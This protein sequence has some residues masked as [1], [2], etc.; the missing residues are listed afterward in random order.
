[1]S[2]FERAL[3]TA[4]FAGGTVEFY[5]TVTQVFSEDF[6][7]R[8][9]EWLARDPV[10]AVAFCDR[11]RQHTGLSALTNQTIMGGL[12]NGRKKGIRPSELSAK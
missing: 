5:T 1:M 7:G 10:Q 3:R 12:E 11:I 6:P 9:Y 4:G 8:T 2:A